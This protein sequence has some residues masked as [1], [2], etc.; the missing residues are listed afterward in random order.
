MQKIYT[1]KPDIVIVT[2]VITTTT[3]ADCQ[4]DEKVEHITTACRIMAK[5]Q[6]IKCQDKVCA[7]TYFNL[8]KESGVKLEDK[9]RYKLVQKLLNKS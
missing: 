8:C 9:H 5:E 7:Q 6:N 2:V 1:V 4:F 3:N